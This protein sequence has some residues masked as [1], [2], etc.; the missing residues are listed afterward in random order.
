MTAPLELVL[1]QRLWAR[2]S[3]SELHLKD[4]R[5]LLASGEKVDHNYLGRWA[6]RLGVDDLYRQVLP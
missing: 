6:A 2:E 3:G 1:S 5:D 4:V